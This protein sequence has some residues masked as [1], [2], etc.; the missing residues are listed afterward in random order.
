MTQVDSDIAITNAPQVNMSVAG[1]R[2]LDIALSIFA[3][4]IVVP[5]LVVLYLVASRDGGPGFYGHERLGKGGRLFKCWKIRT[6][7]VDSE[8]RLEEHLRDNPSA[9]AEWARDHKLRADP[10][11]TRSGR[12]MRETSLD[13][14]PQILNVLRGEMSFVG[15]RPVPRKEFVKY[16]GYE[17]A[18]LS[19]KP[20]ITGVWQVSGRNDVDYAT[21]V[22]MDVQYANSWSVR[23]DLFIIAKTAAAVLARTGL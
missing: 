21:R 3:L 9:A 23:G 1:K 8:E 7:V 18:Y 6:M 15:P 10:R 13:E 20:G 16:D 22:E 4:P 14:L 11:V 5:I 19:V 17:W 12:I 2:L